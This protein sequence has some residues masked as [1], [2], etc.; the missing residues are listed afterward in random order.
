VKKVFA[1]I[2]STDASPASDELNHIVHRGK[3]CIAILNAY[4]YT[5]GHCMVM[6]V[7]HVGTLLDLRAEEAAELWG[8]VTHA[9]GALNVAY[10]PE[11]INVGA[12]L[13][14]AAGAGIPGHLHVHLVPRW[15]GDT[16]FMTA[17]AETRVIPEGL[18]TS[19]RKLHDAW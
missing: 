12:N 11:G 17:I 15:N 18:A 4:P 19:W 13:G 16:N 14:R 10:A 1:L 2:L 5:S 9:T 3:Y 8:F 6:P 7:R